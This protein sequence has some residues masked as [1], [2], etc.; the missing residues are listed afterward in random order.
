MPYFNER[1]HLGLS[2]HKPALVILDIFAAHKTEEIRSLY[3]EHKILLEFVPANCTGELQP[4]DVS[5]NRDLKGYL[6]Q[7]FSDWD[8]DEVTKQ[9][10]TGGIEDKP[11]TSN[12]QASPR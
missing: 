1:E 8:A 10:K 3:A 7:L 2:D 9:L 12:H 5:S 4:L 11:T 6:K